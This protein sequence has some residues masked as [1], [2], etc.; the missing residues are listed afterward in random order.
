MKVPVRWP[1]DEL[2]FRG[3]VLAT[4]FVI[5]K[6]LSNPNIQDLKASLHRRMLLSEASWPCWER[7][8]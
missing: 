4:S 3:H 5:L 6:V 8:P 1:L 7:H 2:Q